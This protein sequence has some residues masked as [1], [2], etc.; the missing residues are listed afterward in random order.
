MSWYLPR[1]KSIS[2]VSISCLKLYIFIQI[3]T[4]CSPFLQF[5]GIFWMT[6]VKIYISI[7]NNEGILKIFFQVLW[8]LWSSY[9]LCSKYSEKYRDNF[10]HR[11]YADHSAPKPLNWL[12]KFIKTNPVFQWVQCKLVCVRSVKNVVFRG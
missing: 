8:A 10:E 7:L 9:N 11:V 12:S 2:F 4:W 5:A 3:F 1:C 6:R